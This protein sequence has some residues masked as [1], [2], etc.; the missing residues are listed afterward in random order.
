MGH[1]NSLCSLLRRPGGGKSKREE[2]DKTQISTD[3]SEHPS[4]LMGVPVRHR[5]PTVD[6][7]VEE[8]LPAKFLLN[9]ILSKLPPLSNYIRDSDAQLNDET[10]SVVSLYR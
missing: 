7:G 1:I 4:S 9:S 8:P 6:T 2:D 10:E 3:A 5:T